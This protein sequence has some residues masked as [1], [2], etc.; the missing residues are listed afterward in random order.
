MRKNDVELMEP[1]TLICLFL[2]KRYFVFVAAA[3]A[4]RDVWYD[5]IRAASNCYV[6]VH[7][8]LNRMCIW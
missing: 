4:D 2:I 6:R 1:F 7:S 8:T 3:A 5:K